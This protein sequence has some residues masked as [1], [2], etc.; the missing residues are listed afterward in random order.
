MSSTR[1]HHFDTR[2]VHA[3][4][5]FNPTSALTPPIF[6]SSTF[7]LDSCADGGSQAASLAPAEFYTRWGNP[8]TKH[9]EAILA[10]LEGSETALAFSSGMGA[11]S[12]LIFSRLEQGDHL[13]LGSSIYSA[14]TELATGVL[15]RFGVEST[16]VDAGGRIRR[17]H[18]FQNKKRL[19]MI[20]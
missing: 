19:M 4:D 18:G 8:T 2:A 10:D 13:V 20:G 11:I 3:G 12:A 16:A 1:P 15:P 7:K 6:Q 5:E 17:L 9:A 14:V